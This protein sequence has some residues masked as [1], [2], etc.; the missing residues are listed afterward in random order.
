M[1]INLNQTPLKLKETA[2]IITLYDQKTYT[3]IQCCNMIQLKR[4]DKEMCILIFCHLARLE[5]KQIL[6]TDSQNGVTKRLL[7]TSQRSCNTNVVNT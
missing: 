3:Y 4:Y 1:T 6:K 7:H 2:G 5:K